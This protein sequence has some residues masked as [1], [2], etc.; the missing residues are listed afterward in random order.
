LE[1]VEKPLR[2]AL[3]LITLLKGNKLYYKAVKAIGVLKVKA[4]IN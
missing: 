3:F 2:V 1:S 4:K